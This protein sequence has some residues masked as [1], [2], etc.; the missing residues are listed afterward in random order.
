VTTPPPPHGAYPPPPYGGYG[1]AQ[2][3]PTNTLAIVSLVCAFVFAPLGIVFGHMS[4]SQIKKSGEEGRGLAI[5][6]LVIGYLVTV[7]TILVVVLSV[8]FFVLL[9]RNLE[10]MDLYRY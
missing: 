9:A 3:R 4:L 2:P 5:A 6:G 1:Y 7:L 8:L 10:N